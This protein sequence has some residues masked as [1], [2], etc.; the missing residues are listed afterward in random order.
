MYYV[1]PCYWLPVNIE[2]HSVQNIVKQGMFCAD[3]TTAKKNF[4][5]EIKNEKM[6]KLRIRLA[7]AN[8]LVFNQPSRNTRSVSSLTHSQYYIDKGLAM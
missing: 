6:F 8:L 2:A 5:L 3:R 1:L 4:P 7:G